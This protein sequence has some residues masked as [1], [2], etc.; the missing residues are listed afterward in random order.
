MVFRKSGTKQVPSLRTLNRDQLYV[1]VHYLL[2]ATAI[3]STMKLVEQSERSKHSTFNLI[4]QPS[5]W[6]MMFVANAEI[7]T[8]MTG[9][10][11]LYQVNV[12]V[13]RVVLNIICTVTSRF[14][15]RRESKEFQTTTWG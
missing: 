4:Q 15:L 9:C 14:L 8:V 6:T 1:P 12:Y 11:C 5:P 7:L 3:N 10:Y 2:F 13:C